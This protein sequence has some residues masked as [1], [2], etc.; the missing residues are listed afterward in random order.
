LGL[1]DS[2]KSR[3][4]KNTFWRNLTVIAGGTAAGEAVTIAASP[5]L[6]RLYV[7]DDFG[8]LSVY[9]S[10]V[11]IVAVVSS[12]SYH[13]AIPAPER[14]EDAANITAL[15]LALVL[16]TALLSAAAA[17]LF[18]ARLEQF[19]GTPGFS[20]YLVAVPLGVLGLSAYEVLA[21][22]AGR[23]KNFGILAA[24]NAQRSIS[25]TAIQLA[26]GVAHVGP[27]GLIVGQLFSQWG[28]TVRVARKS[29]RA[30]SDKFRAVTWRTIAVAARRFRKFPMLTLPQSVLNAIDNNVALLLFAH[31]FGATVTGYFALG[32]RLVS[33][34]FG[35]IGNSAQRVFYPAAA[36]AQVNGTLARE[37]AETYA[38]LLR[39]VLP[40]VLVM[41]ACA[42]ELFA[43]LMGA[44]WREA[45]VYMQWLSLRACF[46][47]LVFPLVP[48]IFVLERHG[49]GTLFSGAQLVVRIG[50]VVIGGR[51]GDA[52][53]TVAL[54]G[55]GTGLQWLI[56]LFYLLKIS[57][58]RV[59][60]A[61][62]RLLFEALI[63]GA[64]ASPIFAVKLLHRGDL[65][66]TITAGVS[67][68]IAAGVMLWRSRRSSPPAS[69]TR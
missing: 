45:G 31:F 44:Q 9:A 64:I 34:P 2:L 28:G 52:R 3:L 32:N 63:A 38:H 20:R 30:D 1:L 40:I 14:D 48:L 67:G 8:L 16:V 61:I 12:L 15:S 26:G 35:L 58:N 46:T 23:K 13:L 68:V 7:P 69:D 29:W 6:S 57:G 62:G 21:Q 18:H 19:L 4:P 25:Q 37:T 43:V 60:D 42:P 55:V 39:L 24:A 17:F 11:S 47:M 54:L 65:L 41:T 49:V 59:L 53:L 27:I 22:W 10:L 56:Y 50:A 33:I 5:V 36:A 66:V 51:L